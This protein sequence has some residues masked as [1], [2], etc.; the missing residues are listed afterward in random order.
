MK[1]I[2]TMFCA[3]AVLMPT[4]QMLAACTVVIISMPAKALRLSTPKATMMPSMIGTRQ[5]T[6][7]V[8]EGTRNAST[9]PTR[10]VPITT[11]LVRAPTRDRMMSA[12]RLSRP[13]VVMAAARNRAAAT[14]TSAVLAKPLNARVERGA[15]AQQ[16]VGIGRHSARV[17]SRNAISA[18][19]TTARNG[20]IDG[21]RHPDDDGESEYG[22][23]VMAGDRQS[24]RRRQ[25]Q[26]D[27]QHGYRQQQP[28]VCPDPALRPTSAVR[29]TGR[30]VWSTIAMRI[31]PG[32]HNRPCVREH[33]FAPDLPGDPHR[34]RASRG[35]PGFAR[36]FDLAQS[37]AA[38]RS[39][40]KRLMREDFTMRKAPSLSISPE[41]VFF[42]IAKSR[43]SDGAALI[44]MP[45]PPLPRRCRPWLRGP[46][47]HNGPLG[48]FRLY[49]RVESRRAGRPGRA[50]V[51]RPRRRRSRPS[52]RSAPGGF[53]RSQQPYGA[54]P[55]R[56]A[57]ACRLSR[58]GLVAVRHSFE[59]F[60]EPL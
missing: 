51:T 41:K 27:G 32:R 50:D 20:V 48:A 4:F 39:L 37:A 60:E 16:H 49:P 52:E 54:V 26:D 18:A 13:V 23:H 33:R 34:W 7:A 25:Q 3:A 8:V 55:D 11:W 57:D 29:R 6:R 9:K 17:P 1:P 2:A 43:Q 24:C 42:I 31:P 44:W 35:A 56:D 46:Q 53:A 58:R 30:R 22:E 59:D 19:I 21:L 10:M 15:R 5:A 40:P 12:M 14:S 38:P 47:Q 45:I 28:P 36:L